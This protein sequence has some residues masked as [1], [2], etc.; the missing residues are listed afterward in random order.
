MSDLSM[1]PAAIRARNNRALKAAAKLASVTPT[2][3]TPTI[4]TMLLLAGPSGLTFP[5][6]PIMGLIEILPPET[7]VALTDIS[8]PAGWTSL[9]TTSDAEIVATP[10]PTT[11]PV[12]L[13]A[14]PAKKPVVAA[15]NSLL[16]A[17]ICAEYRKRE[18]EAFRTGGD[19][20]NIFWAQQAYKILPND[21]G[22]ELTSLRPVAVMLAPGFYCYQPRKGDVS[23]TVHTRKIAK[24]IWTWV[25]NMTG[26]SGEATNWHIEN[27]ARGR[28]TGHMT[29]NR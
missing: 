13:L 27:I 2:M 29:A 1:T 14:A 7:A 17:A 8:V 18:G 10:A 25:D 9:D 5:I 22:E 26:E 12:L 6:V 19:N 16:G 28:V 21:S 3:P 23:I 20:P 15:S 4:P 24:N 11:A